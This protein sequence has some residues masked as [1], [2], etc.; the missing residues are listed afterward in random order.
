MYTKNCNL[1]DENSISVYKINR[2]KDC[3]ES[4]N[5]LS[6]FILK[7]NSILIKL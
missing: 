7:N 3:E 4:E 1:I 6:N 5:E 2:I